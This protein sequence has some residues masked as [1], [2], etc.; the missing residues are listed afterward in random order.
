MYYHLP[1]VT[2]Q[3][4]GGKESS[5]FSILERVFHTKFQPL[6]TAT[7][8]LGSN[9]TKTRWRSKAHFVVGIVLVKVFNR[10]HFS[11]VWKSYV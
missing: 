8:E 7:L 9:D 3:T 1:R 10:R 4:S 6:P 11:S 2:I 5:Y